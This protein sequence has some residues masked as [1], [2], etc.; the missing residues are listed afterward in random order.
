MKRLVTF[1]LAALFITA[2]APAAFGCVCAPAPPVAEAL[3][4]AA[5]VFSGKFVGAEYRKGII[6]GVRRVM[7][8]TIGEKQEYE[9]LVLKFE[10]EQWW[11][12]KPVKEVVLATEQTRGADGSEIVGD[13]GFGFAEGERY[14]VYAYAEEEGLQT[15]S[16]TRTKR[17]A[18]ARKDLKALGKG[19]RPR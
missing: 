13:C 4:E 18:K 11:K 16:C 8:Q 7:E 15:G 2:L 5:A 17:L 10:A 3:S 14:L 19:E 1:S 6:S 9:V 12:G